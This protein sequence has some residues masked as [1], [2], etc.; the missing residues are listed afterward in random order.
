MTLYPLPMLT[1]IYWLHMLATVVWVGGQAALALL[2]LPAAR[3]TLKSEDFTSFFTQVNRKL[4][5]V[6]WISL[7]VLIGTGMFQ[8]SASPSYQGFLSI[9]NTWAVAILTKHLVIAL[10]IGLSAYSTWGLAPALQRLSL[11]RSHGKGSEV[12]FKAL[13]KKEET[14][15]RI[16]LVISIV[17]LLLTAWAR[18]AV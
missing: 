2:V 3:K 7:T 11:L 13:Q 10:L 6:G 12:E 9:T 15:V 5:L 18:S 8:M 1:A 16:N 17:V 14:L 4:Q